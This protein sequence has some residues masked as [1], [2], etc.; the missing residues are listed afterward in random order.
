M[1]E[2]GYNLHYLR[3]FYTVAQILLDSKDLPKG[4]SKEYMNQSIFEDLRH[5]FALTNY[6]KCV[7]SDD[8]KNSGVK[9]SETMEKIVQKNCCL[10]LNC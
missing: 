9:H 8:N 6:Y 3:I 2:A 5:S 10:K 4:F 1:E 7:F